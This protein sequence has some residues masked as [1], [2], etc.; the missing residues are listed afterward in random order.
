MTP[1][2]IN[3]ELEALKDHIERR[4]MDKAD[5]ISLFVSWLGAQCGIHARTPDEARI[6]AQRLAGFIEQNAASVSES[7]RGGGRVN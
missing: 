4:G 2:Q 3:R 7:L 5:A 6:K 1:A